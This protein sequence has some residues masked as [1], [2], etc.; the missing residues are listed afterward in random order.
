MLDCA[1]TF[2]F[3]D[4]ISKFF[5]FLWQKNEDIH[6]IMLPEGRHAAV[7]SISGFY[8]TV[9]LLWARNSNEVVFSCLQ[10]NFENICHILEK[11]TI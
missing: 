10:G 6:I 2:A 11:N 4:G 5:Q 9:F 3:V 1:K 8:T 7:T